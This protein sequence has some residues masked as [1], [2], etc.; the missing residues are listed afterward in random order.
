VHQPGL[1]PATWTVS[2][3]DE[4]RRF[5]WV[6]R[7]PGIQMV[8][9]HGVTQDSPATS[10]VVLRFSFGGLM[11]GIIGRIFRNVAESYL[12]QEA[13]SLKQRVESA[14]SGGW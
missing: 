4:P 3:I 8:A 1:R 10:R 12:A 13:A 14:P 2:E 11:G 9:E 5:V 6:A 7:S